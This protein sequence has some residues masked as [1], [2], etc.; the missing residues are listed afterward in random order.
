MNEVID[1]IYENITLKRSSRVHSLAS[2]YSSVKINNKTVT[3]DPLMLYQR[4]LMLK[5]SDEDLKF[6][7]TYDL[8]P[9]PMPFFKDGEMRKTVKST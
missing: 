7:L 9:Y 6:Y 8:A 4:M 1:K 3:I 5:E 2:L